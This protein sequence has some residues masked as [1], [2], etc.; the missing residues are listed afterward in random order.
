M[1]YRVANII[2]IIIICAVSCGG[3]GTLCI[4][5]QM[6][7]SAKSTTSPS[8][9]PSGTP[10]PHMPYINQCRVGGGVHSKDSQPGSQG[11]ASGDYVADL[12]GRRLSEERRG[13]RRYQ[14][15]K[16]YSSSKKRKRMWAPPPVY[17]T[18]VSANGNV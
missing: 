8:L 6:F 18:R 4:C 3:R 12:C 5:R 10:E 14:R 1:S 2:I 16:L 17:L 9:F 11:I 15:Q 7:L 13:A